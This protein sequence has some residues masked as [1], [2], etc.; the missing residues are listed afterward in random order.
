MVWAKRIL[1]HW[2]APLVR[3]VFDRIVE[4][5]AAY[6]A[7]GAFGVWWGS[8]DRTVRSARPQDDF[9]VT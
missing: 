4:P 1:S 7:D 2:L 3:P 6:A 9:P 8:G 5:F